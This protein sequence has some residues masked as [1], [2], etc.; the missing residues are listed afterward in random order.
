[1]LVLKDDPAPFFQLF[2]LASASDCGGSRREEW[3]KHKPNSNGWFSNV[4][5]HCVA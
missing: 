2:I 1:M 5:L 3:I 4:N